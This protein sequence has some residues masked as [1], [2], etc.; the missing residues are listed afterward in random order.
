VPPWRRRAAPPPQQPARAGRGGAG[1][2]GAGR[3]RVGGLCSAVQ[4][5]RR[6]SRQM[7]GVKKMQEN[8]MLVNG[9]RGAWDR[10]RGSECSL[11]GRRKRG[12][13]ALTGKYGRPAA[14]SPRGR[15]SSRRLL[16]ATAWQ[17]PPSSCCTCGSVP[18]VNRSSGTK[19][20]GVCTPLPQGTVRS[21][22]G[23]A[24]SDQVVAT[25][26]WS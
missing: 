1:R 12:A 22:V 7:Q 4:Q 18:F 3:H 8:V 17:P 13:A 26:L 21:C 11:L 2:G 5:R 9:E 24:K 10:S 14:A 19:V 15:R 25:V 16:A 23:A 6:D 20:T